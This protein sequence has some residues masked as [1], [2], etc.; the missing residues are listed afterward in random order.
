MIVG[1][2]LENQSALAQLKADRLYPP[3]VSTG[4]SEIIAE[5]KFPEWPCQVRCDRDDVSLVPMKKAGQWK[6]TIKD[7]AAPGIAWLRFVDATSA[8]ALMPLLISRVP[9]TAETDK[10]HEHYR[11]AQPLVLPT[12][13]AGRLS[14][15][16]QV[17]C[18]RISIK[19][20][21]TLVLSV[22]ANQ[23]L[24]SPMDA[25]L[26]LTDE[27]GNVFA[28]ADD[29][30]NLDPQL[31]FTAKRDRNI[32]VRVFAFP[33]TPN[34]TIEFAGASSF[35]Y[36]LRATVGPFLDHV[37]PILI[38]KPTKS[39]TPVGWNLTSSELNRFP[40]TVLMGETV[41]SPGAIGWHVLGTADKSAETIMASSD[42]KSPAQVD[43][44][45]AV[46]AGK[47][48]APKQIDRFRFTVQKGKRYIAKSYSRA[49]GFR[50]DTVLSAIN[51]SDK[52][53]IARHDD[54]SRTKFDSEL[55]FKA[56]YDGE[57]ELQVADAVDKH[58]PRHAYAVWLHEQKPTVKLTIDSGQ[59]T[60]KPGGSIEITININRK[61]GHKKPLQ[62][63]ATGLP[64]EVTLS[65]AIADPKGGTSKS[66]KLKLTAKPK[67]KHQGE[68]RIHAVE[69]ESDGSPSTKYIATNRLADQFDITQLW[70]T[71]PAK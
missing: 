50:V 24:Q 65:K 27:R 56:S 47:I 53:Q 57:V 30:R 19:S 32:I 39:I 22:I 68:F 7:D 49:Q 40:A 26:Q 36:T 43:Q 10:N 3:V 70:L 63:S 16:R 44:I 18:Y 28:Q 46:L 55:N 5:G 15:S 67:T 34:S 35:V 33:A 45:P 13:V 48:L 6:V 12:A 41:F 23:Y 58:G 71:V 1:L 54:T 42:P 61:N 9:V 2:A 31:V 4:V 37:H 52:K 17:D 11:D 66:I 60:I 62:F 38:G 51:P 25:V 64:P 69:L 14:K 21:E 29:E 20:G 8:S 59:W